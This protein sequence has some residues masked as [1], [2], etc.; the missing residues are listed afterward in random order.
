VLVVSQQHLKHFRYVM[1]ENPVTMFAF[2]LFALIV[3]L[4]IFGPFITPHDPLATNATNTLKPPSWNHAFGTDHLGRDV[5][6]RVIAATRLDLGIAVSAVALSFFIGGAL[7]CIA[8]FWGGW[9]DR[10]VGRFSDT[11]MAFP[12]FVLA[13]GIVASMGNT[14]ENIIYATAII[15]LPFYA[16]VARAETS[17]RRNAGYVYAAR[18]CG[19]SDARIL[20]TQIFPN[21]LPPM[22]VQISLNMGWAILNAAGLSFIGLGVRPPDAEWGIMVAEGANYIVSGEWW[23]AIFPGVALMLAVFCFNLLGDGLRDL[24]DPLRRT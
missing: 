8:G 6:S 3:F 2:S 4:A 24:V 11:I 14:V 5:F 16:R 12:L 1:G 10:I 18:L 9:T 19:S 20:A 22:M 17:I 21:I 15:N 23:L 13:M 7:G